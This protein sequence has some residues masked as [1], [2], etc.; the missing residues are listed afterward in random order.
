MVGDKREYTDHFWV[1]GSVLIEYTKVWGP[2]D[3]WYKATHL[4]CQIAEGIENSPL[5]EGPGTLLSTRTHSRPR[6]LWFNF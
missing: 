5:V 3:E 2:W 4:K 1:H 6:S